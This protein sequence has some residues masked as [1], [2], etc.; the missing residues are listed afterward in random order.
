MP[1]AEK[2]SSKDLANRMK[3]KGL[4]KLKWFCQVCEKQCRDDNGFKCHMMSESHLRQMLVVGES[5][6]KHI[7]DYSSNFQSEFLALLS[8]RWGTKRVKAN[9]VY[10]EYIQDKNHLHM[11]A[12][13]WVSLTEFIKH[14]GR[15]GI[16]HV[17]DT[18][19]GWFVSW[20]DNSPK[21]LSRQA[22][23]QSKERQD[24]DDE[25]RQRKHI[26]EQIERA[27]AAEEEKK[28]RQPQASTSNKSSNESS[29]E[30][31]G[32][33][34]A[35]GQS[36]EK[37]DKPVG[38]ISISL[39]LPKKDS[40]PIEEE[41][42]SSLTPVAA[43]VISSSSIKINPFKKANPLKS[44]AFKSASKAAVPAAAQAQ[45]SLSAVEQLMK[46]EIERKRRR[47]EGFGGNDAKRVRV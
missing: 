11:N 43:S 28:L 47:E 29:G 42:T 13:R 27:K 15:S 18:D 30:E 6:G 3:S 1:K 22:A 4:Q 17:D 14:L 40:P 12:T 31:D 8:R 41:A 36:Q 33:A 25:Q 2:G 38:P 45:H 34:S 32:S 44:N 46:E 26:A 20:I 24:M 19:K 23:N 10:Q 16:V 7:S 37:E 21:S 9:T 39:A 35:G 5:A